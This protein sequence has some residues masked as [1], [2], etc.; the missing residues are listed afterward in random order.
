MVKYFQDMYLK[1][2][3][4]FVKNSFQLPEPM[5]TYYEC[6]TPR[7]LEILKDVAL[8]NIME[9]LNAGNIKVQ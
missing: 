6:L 9:A 2:S 5:I 1:N 8:P 7:Y 3:D 4:N